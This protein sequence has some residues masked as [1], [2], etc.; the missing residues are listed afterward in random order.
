MEKEKPRPEPGSVSDG[1]ILHQI[2]GLAGRVS[3][4]LTDCIVAEL[5][6]LENTLHLDD[7]TP[8]AHQNLCTLT[9]CVL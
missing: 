9:V 1:R 6:V 2:L 4:L 3:T 5:S 7:S 8:S